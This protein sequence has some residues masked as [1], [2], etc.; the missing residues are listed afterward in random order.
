MAMNMRYAFIRWSFG[1]KPK[2]ANKS[3]TEVDMRNNVCIIFNAM[4]NARPGQE[5][6]ITA[7]MRLIMTDGEAR[8]MKGEVAAR[9]VGGVRMDGNLSVRDF[10]FKVSG[11]WVKRVQ[12]FKTVC[13]YLRVNAG[14]GEKLA[15]AFEGVLGQFKGQ[16]WEV[17][18]NGCSAF[19][20]GPFA[21]VRLRPPSLAFLRAAEPC[22][23]LQIGF[24]FWRA[25]L[26]YVGGC[27]PG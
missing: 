22:S 14:F 3:S 13:G 23:A 20:G 25:S 9:S 27:E 24:R 8:M 12:N 1:G 5:V 2:W 4:H 26:F 16:V 11:F 10:G 15:G 19:L 7:T 17:P 21:F 18:R 6:R